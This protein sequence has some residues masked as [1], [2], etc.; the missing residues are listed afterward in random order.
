M[1]EELKED[2]KKDVKII[3]ILT[4]E[5]YEANAYKVKGG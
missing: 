5:S 4:H 2:I 1:L 3:S